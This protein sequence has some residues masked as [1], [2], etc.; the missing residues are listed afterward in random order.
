MTYEAF[1]K[2]QCA[3]LLVGTDKAY[4]QVREVIMRRVVVPLD[5]TDVAESILPDARRVAGSKGELILIHDASVLPYYG[6]SYLEHQRQAVAAS[7]EYLD[8]VAQKLQGEGLIV[9]TQTTFM[10]DAAI[11]IDEAVRMF[12]ADMVAA[13]THARGPFSRLFRR[14]VAWRALANCSVPVLL[15]HVHKDQLPPSQP[16]ERRI[17]VPLDGS[18]LAEKS[19]PLAEQLADEWNA[20]IWLT[21]VVFTLSVA[22]ESAALASAGPMYEDIESL[23]REAEAY[24]REVAAKLKG[25][26]HTRVLL[27]SAS[28]DLVAATGAWGI[29]D[30]V[31]ASHGRTGLSR[32]ILGSVADSLIH[33]LDLPIV[34]IPAFA[35]HAG[36]G[37]TA[38][39]EISEDSAV[40]V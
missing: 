24:L 4:R 37:R 26:V 18:I 5:G 30:I 12:G 13:A 21:Q 15:R 27:G 6:V 7:H 28:N 34:V 32:V 22:P 2:A 8:A 29:S 38:S 36:A 31:M 1:H 33:H 35:V 39:A 9:Q 25:T 17:L 16:S 19:L 3:V 20:E 10:G 40:P 23:E 11:A 14:S